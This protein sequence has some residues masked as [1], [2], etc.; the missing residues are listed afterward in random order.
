M[1][2]FEKRIL[3]KLKKKNRGDNQLTK[4]ID[5]LINDIEK[6][7]WKKPIEL[8]KTRP[9]AD[10][11]HS[12]GFY[13][14]N[15]KIHRTMIMIEFEQDKAIVVWAGSHNQYEKTFQNNRNVIEKWLRDK[16]WIK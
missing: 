13:F 7:S 10:C 15:I 9:D 4:A 12:D 3:E 8:I 5:D 14:F 16:N 6:E 11:V 1:K 2:L